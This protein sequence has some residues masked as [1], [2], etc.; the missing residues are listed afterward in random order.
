MNLIEIIRT[1]DI[2][3]IKQAIDSGADINELNSYG[4]TCL[5]EASYSGLLEIVEILLCKGMN[6]NTKGSK[7]DTPLH[8]AAFV[9]WLE[10]CELLIRKGADVNAKNKRDE[11][12]LHTAV[13][14]FDE[15]RIEIVELLISNNANLNEGA[16]DSAR[17]D[18]FDYSE[19]E[20]ETK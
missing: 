19:A 13:G 15:D 6:V 10:I 16:L 20:R 12:P 7:D 3:A 4:N 5:N 18:G 14:A 17:V 1:E 11:T 9:G 2:E 8:H